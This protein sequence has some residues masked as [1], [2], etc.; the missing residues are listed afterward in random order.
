MLYTK[1]RQNFDLIRLVLLL[2]ISCCAFHSHAL[3]DEKKIT[4]EEYRDLG[5]VEQQKGNLPQALTYYIKATELGLDNA[6]VMN[7]IGIIYEKA[8]FISKAEVYYLKSV[9][10][11]EAYLP[12]L[13]NL[14]YLYQGQGKNELAFEYFQKRFEK[15]D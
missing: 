4:A 11:D 9:H 14:A 12:A 8:D 7:D 6:A 13:M 15:G 2:F 10:T 5:F 1:T 3:A